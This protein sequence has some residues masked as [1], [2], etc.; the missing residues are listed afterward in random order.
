MLAAT[1]S[2]HASHDASFNLEPGNLDVAVKHAVARMIAHCEAQ[3]DIAKFLARGLVIDSLGD[4]SEQVRGYFPSRINVAPIID[5]VSFVVAENAKTSRQRFQEVILSYV[6]DGKIP[7]VS[8]ANMQSFIKWYSVENVVG[9]DY[10]GHDKRLRPGWSG[11]AGEP[12][13]MLKQLRLA[14]KKGFL[15]EVKT[16]DIQDSKVQEL[17]ADVPIMQAFG[18]DSG[19]VSAAAETLG[20]GGEAAKEVQKI[21][22]QLVEIKTLKTALNNAGDTPE[23][24]NIAVT[25][26]VKTQALHKTIETVNAPQGNTPQAPASAPV[27]N[28]PE[29]KSAVIIEPQAVL[30]QST[31]QVQDISVAQVTPQVTQTSSIQ[32]V[33]PTATPVVKTPVATQPTNSITPAPVSSISTALPSAVSVQPVSAAPSVPTSVINSALAVHQTAN[34]QIQSRQMTQA[35]NTIATALPPAIVA[36]TAN[37]VSPKNASVVAVARAVQEIKA[38][39]AT[40]NMPVQEVVAMS[41]LPDAPK[42][43]SAPVQN[44]AQTLSQP[45]AISHVT[46]SLPPQTAE[47]IHATLTQPAVTQVTQTPVNVEAVATTIQQVA[48]K[49]ENPT[50]QVAAQV[51]QQT[52]TQNTEVQAVAPALQAQALQS[53]IDNVQALQ[54]S[55]SVPP[56]AKPALQI[57]EAQLETAVQQIK[58][59]EPAQPSQPAIVPADSPLGAVQEAF[60]IEPTPMP[61]EPKAPAV[62]TPAV[63]KKAEVTPTPASQDQKPAAAPAQESKAATPPIEQP[64]MFESRGTSVADTIKPD[65]STEA[66][67]KLTAKGKCANCFS[68][69]AN[70]GAMASMMAGLEAAKTSPLETSIKPKSTVS[71]SAVKY[72]PKVS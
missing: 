70:C 17:I 49:I 47:I 66:K 57:I 11:G 20:N 22:E 45:D 19:A 25:L 16:L 2:E 39:A 31:P 33:A 21:I 67:E 68:D 18:G 27:Q 7:D 35:I 8:Q 34:V 69:C 30:Q 55:N 46:Q 52:V 61:A 28:A 44:F 36:R 4:V 38:V 5:D 6:G 23:A 9:S 40:Q 15:L 41:M 42:T 60:K 58:A 1:L 62:E 64:A 63:V 59:P 12:S 26:G 53:V 50:L 24:A 10:D 14:T 51:A 32:P 54:I 71:E 56:T 3:P 37:D 65:T 29:A 48:Q 13:D 43:F 72:K